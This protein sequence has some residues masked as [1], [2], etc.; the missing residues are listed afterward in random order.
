[1]T[2]SSRFATHAIWRDVVFQEGLRYEWLLHGDMATAALHKAA[3]QLKSSQVYEDLAKV[4]LTHQNIALAGYIP[5]VSQP[6]QENGI[7]LFSLSLLLT[8]WAFASK[9]L[10]EGLKSSRVTAVFG[11]DSSDGLLPIG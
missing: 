10:P 2:M 4:A 8:I 11:A 9:E 5:A 6:N 1:M 7:A 3:L